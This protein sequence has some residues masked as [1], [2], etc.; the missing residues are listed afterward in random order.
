MNPATGS[1]ESY[2]PFDPF[3]TPS[4]LAENELEKN[5]FVNSLIS[6]IQAGTL[7]TEDVK[8]EL[9]KMLV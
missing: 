9:E 3:A 7:K 6:Q 2:E 4:P 8:T 5:E 1:T